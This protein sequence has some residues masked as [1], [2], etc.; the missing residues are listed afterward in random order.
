[1][2]HVFDTP[3]PPVLYV[4]IGSGHVAVTAADVE[5]TTIEVS[6]SHADEVLVEQRGHEIVVIAPKKVGFFSA[7]RN[8]TVEARVPANCELS[9]R[10]GSASVVAAGTLGWA[11]IHV[12]SGDVTLEHVSAE[13]LVKTGSGDID[14]SLIE[15][16]AN[17]SSGSGGITLDR[18]EGPSQIST[19]SGD[20]EVAYSGAPLAVKSGSG[21]LKVRDASA[22]ISLSSGSGN[23]LVDRF[24]AGKLT[25]K[26]A[27][28]DIRIGIPA[29]VP[30][31]T[32]VSSVSGRVTSSL[33]GA[34]QPAEGQ[35]FVEL[36]AKTV[37]GDVL[38]RQL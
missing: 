11:K 8:I 36:R 6:G 9:T 3:E 33:E 18:L 16:P 15:G 21:D 34:G 7:G 25:A 32:D 26:N 19:G 28:G 14:I 24:P 27:S 17:I 23:L 29:G 10:L 12:G 35:D 20:I 37:S 31:W 4:E 22:D 30:V 1:M 2:Q 13:A 38:L 5:Q